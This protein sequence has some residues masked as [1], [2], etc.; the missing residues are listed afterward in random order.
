MQRGYLLVI[1]GM[2]PASVPGVDD[3]AYVWR[4]CWDNG[5]HILGSSNACRAQGPTTTLNKR[6]GRLDSTSHPWQTQ[7]NVHQAV[8]VHET[9][10]C[11]RLLRRG[12]WRWRSTRG[13]T[14]DTAQSCANCA[15]TDAA[16]GA[17]ADASSHYAIHWRDRAHGKPHARVGVLIRRAIEST[18]TATLQ[19]ICTLRMSCCARAGPA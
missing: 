8:D 10:L 12:R 4:R 6:T 9:R 11:V 2:L 5:Q 16:G 1:G 17:A 18:P 15:C 14:D 3:P 19:P 7:S 13:A